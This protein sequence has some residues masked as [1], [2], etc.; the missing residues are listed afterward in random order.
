MD[1]FPD[2]EIHFLLSSTS[3][4][5]LRELAHPIGLPLGLRS[6]KHGVETPHTVITDEGARLGCAA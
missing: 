1:V 6:S 2:K 5:F 4:S 3:F